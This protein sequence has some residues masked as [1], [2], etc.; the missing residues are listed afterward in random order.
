MKSIKMLAIAAAFASVLSTTATAEEFTKGSLKI[1]APWAR[2]SI[3]KKGNSAAYMKISNAAAEADTLI[4]VKVS[5]AG[6]A[7][8]HTHI[9]DNGVMRMRQ[10]KGGITV[11]AHGSV[12]LQPG[13]YH[14]MLMRLKE[15]IKKGTM[16]PITLVFKN[17]GKVTVRASVQMSATMKGHMHKKDDAMPMKKPGTHKHN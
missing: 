1:E 17:A 8:L 16:L 3:G 9:N 6:K 2:P 10:V 11:P 12:A 7:E 14:V 13:G 15:P 5:Q 4:D